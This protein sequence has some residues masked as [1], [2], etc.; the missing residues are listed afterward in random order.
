MISALLAWVFLIA[1]ILTKEVQYFIV[2]GLFDIASEI[3]LLYD[4]DD[5]E[6]LVEI[7]A[8]DEDESEIENE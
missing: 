6:V 8:E 4:R 5:E 3:W 2:A 7:K 1:G